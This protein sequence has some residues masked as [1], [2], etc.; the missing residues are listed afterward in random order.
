[1][2]I[3]EKKK[4][5]SASHKHGDA[6]GAV[7]D[8][9]DEADSPVLEDINDPAQKPDNYTIC[10]PQLLHLDRDGRPL[11]FNGWLLPNKFEPGQEQKPLSFEAF[12]AE[13]RDFREPAAWQLMES[14]ICCLTGDY[15][16]EFTRE[17]KAVLKMIVDAGRR[18]GALDKEQ[19]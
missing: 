4:T 15:F 18:S 6:D 10:A 11:W 7:D 13:P 8:D 12:L 2:G 5:K 3:L 9:G 1:M 19:T 16:S 14:N 17:E